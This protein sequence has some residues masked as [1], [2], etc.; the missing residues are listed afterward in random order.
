MITRPLFPLLFV[1]GW[2]LAYYQRNIEARR[3]DGGALPL[4]LKSWW[5]GPRVVPLGKIRRVSPNS[6]CVTLDETFCCD[7]IG[8]STLLLLEDGRPLPLPHASQ[9]NKVASHGMGRWTHRR[10]N[11]YFSP[12]DNADLTKTPRKYMLIDGLGTNPEI[13]GALS[14]LAQS[15]ASFANPAAYA[16][17]KLQLCL[18]TR[19]GLG[20]IRESDDRHLVVEGLEL[21]LTTAGLP[22]L[23]VARIAL[24]IRAEAGTN[25]IQADLEGVAWGELG[26]DELRISLEI[27]EDYRPS[28]TAL[29]ATARGRLI[30]DLTTTRADGQW[31]GARLT[32]ACLDTLRRE[33]ALACGG[34]EARDR[35]LDAI[36]A[37]LSSGAL[38]M[39]LSLPPDSLAALR[40]ALVKE[41]GD[42]VLTLD[43]VRAGSTINLTARTA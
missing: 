3:K 39:G 12:T 14:R 34:R 35:W 42:A 8:N 21:G 31:H 4:L 15:R 5:L 24:D 27:D 20:N 41:D 19:L 38:P 10:Q 17:R 6:Y 1:S 22:D 11:I 30:A 43:L 37:D 29:S 25:R 23:S 26:L 16:L 9:V 33:L 7:S 13:Y 40:S 32:L 28:L 2:L 18:G 36:L